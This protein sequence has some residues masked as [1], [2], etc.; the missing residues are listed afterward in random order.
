MKIV[1]SEIIIKGYVRAYT[2][3]DG[4]VRVPFYISLDNGLVNYGQIEVSSFELVEPNKRDLSRD[5]KIIRLIREYDRANEPYIYFNYEKIE[6]ICDELRDL[7]VEILDKNN[8]LYWRW[9]DDS[10]V[11]HTM[12]RRH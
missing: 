12:R 6:Y 1:E 10:G 11:V 2:D 5:E 3:D 4:N 8:E 7:G 9:I